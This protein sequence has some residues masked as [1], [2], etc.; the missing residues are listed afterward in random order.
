MHKNNSK[1]AEQSSCHHQYSCNALY[2][3]RALQYA[4]EVRR[5]EG[6]NTEDISVFHLDD[7]SLITKQTLCSVLTYLEDK[8]KPISEGLIIYPL[9]QKERIK[10]P[11][12]MDT[13]RPF[14]CY[15][16]LEFMNTGKP[17]FI[18]GSNLLNSK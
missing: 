7:E 14:C 1:I 9:K 10:F 3:G 5:E 13:L 15:E 8:P 11:H 6:K 16:C 18:H 4:V 12:L 2:K 17:A